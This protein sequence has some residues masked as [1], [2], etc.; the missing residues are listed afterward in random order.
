VVSIWWLG[1]CRVRLSRFQLEYTKRNP[2]ILT[3]LSH[4]A[5]EAQETYVDLPH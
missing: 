2:L 5:D 4:E 3:R 1:S